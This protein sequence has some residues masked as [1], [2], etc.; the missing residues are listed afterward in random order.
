MASPWTGTFFTARD[1]AFAMADGDCYDPA[2]ADH[3]WS[4]VSD[5]L[6][7]ELDNE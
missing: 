6:A 3:A 2:L 4:L 5:F 1:T 7:R